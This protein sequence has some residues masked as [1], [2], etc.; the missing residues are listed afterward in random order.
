MYD[1]FLLEVELLQ[2][3][4]DMTPFTSWSQASAWRQAA[5]VQI[6]KEKLWKERRRAAPPTTTEEDHSLV[7]DHNR[8]MQLLKGRA[9][10]SDST[11]GRRVAA[12]SLVR[13][14][15]GLRELCRL[16]L[17]SLVDVVKNVFRDARADKLPPRT[18]DGVL[19][20]VTKHFATNAIFGLGLQEVDALFLQILHNCSLL[21]VA[22]GASPKIVQ[23]PKT[24]HHGRHRQALVLNK[25]Q[26]DVSTVEFS[27]STHLVVPLQY[28]RSVRSI[29]SH[30]R[31]F[32]R[33]AMRQLQF[34]EAELD[35][36]QRQRS[37]VWW[38]A[39]VKSVID[40]SQVHAELR[41]SLTAD[42]W[43][44]LTEACEI[45]H[46]TH[47]EILE[48]IA[49]HLISGNSP[50][51]LLGTQRYLLRTISLSLLDHLQP[52]E[53]AREETTAVT[54]ARTLHRSI[55]INQY[56]AQA[57]AQRAEEAMSCAATLRRVF[58]AWC[59]LA[60][61]KKL[62]WDIVRAF[63]CRQ[64]KLRLSFIWKAWRK[65]TSLR[66]WTQ[67]SSTAESPGAAPLTETKRHAP[68]N[69]HDS[70]L[71]LDEPGS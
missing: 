42:L 32:I 5:L 59:H 67:G 41:E 60:A 16:S 7:G 61:A 30:W 9:G 31:H 28:A 21:H 69:N 48:V 33:D 65:R 53:N 35:H 52:R 8:S 13:E 24:A 22:D 40:K 66:R 45:H 44:A 43:F 68:V 3:V 62:E 10:Q 51:L 20:R 19:H 2:K 4:P 23:S 58:D 29:A 71:E 70:P 64:E 36:A 50:P 26:I 57:H 18:A 46:T 6:M 14:S 56:R 38:F 27:R 55:I 11:Q 34:D 1:D 37:I 47:W 63:G 17:G 25:R 49:V 54:A 12:W 15:S 39:E